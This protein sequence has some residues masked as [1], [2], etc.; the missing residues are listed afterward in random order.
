MTTSS[1]A[2]EDSF[3][4][5]RFSPYLN[6]AQ[7]WTCSPKTKTRKGLSSL[8]PFPYS[9]ATLLWQ[10]SWD[11][12]TAILYLWHISSAP[13][14][15]AQTVFYILPTSCGPSLW[16]AH[17][18]YHIC[19][20]LTFLLKIKAECCSKMVV[21]IYKTRQKHNPHHNLNTHTMTTS[22][23]FLTEEEAFLHFI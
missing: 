9:S 18:I 23:L 10:Q 17:I 3:W 2:K 14:P 8:F 15:L 16:P 19:N 22:I 21:S 7:V 6:G 1:T 13:F 20:L 12:K 11:L 5:Y 4:E